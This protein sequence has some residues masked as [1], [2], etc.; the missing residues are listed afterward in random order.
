MQKKR[1]NKKKF[2]KTFNLK[3]GKK[4]LNKTFIRLFKH[5]FIL[6]TLETVCQFIIKIRKG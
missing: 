3:L 1:Y 4:I 6:K 5:Y 2:N